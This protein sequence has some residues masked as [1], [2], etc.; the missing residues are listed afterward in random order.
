MKSSFHAAFVPDRGR[1]VGAAIAVAAMLLV[2]CS[3]GRDKG[4]S[5]IAAKVNKEE[6]TVQQVNFVLQQQRGIKPEQVDTASR[7]MLE[8]LIDQELAVQKAKELKLDRDPWVMQAIEAAKR[9]ILARAYVD[10]ASDAAVKPSPGDIAKYYNDKPSL[11]K[12]RRVYSIQ[13]LAIEAAP[14]QIPML[15]NE[16]STAK[17]ITDFIDYLKSSNLRFAVNQ[18]VRAAE[19]LPPATLDMFAKLKDGQA[20]LIP[21]ATGAQV[22]VLAGSRTEPV[23]EARAKPAIEQYL[24]LEA[25]RKLAEADMKA[26]RAAAKIEYMGKFAQSA[27]SAAAD[28]PKPAEPVADGVASASVSTPAASGLDAASVSRGLGVK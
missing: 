22:V 7:Q 5:R 8:R 12:D 4:A 28:T 15:R 6:L 9:D 20:I 3:G 13:E 18:A 24:H 10:K 27:D 11:F 16:L 17:S 25:R 23:D 1:A 14:A 19:Q 26:M 21:V 2:G